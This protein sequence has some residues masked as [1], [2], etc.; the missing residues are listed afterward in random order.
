MDSFIRGL[1]HSPPEAGTQTAQNGCPAWN[2]S[3]LVHCINQSCRRYRIE[4]PIACPG[5]CT[6]LA[7]P[8]YGPIQEAKQK[9]SQ[10]GWCSR[11]NAVALYPPLMAADVNISLVEEGLPPGTG[12]TCLKMLQQISLCTKY[13][14]WILW[15]LYSIYQNDTVEKKGSNVGLTIVLSVLLLVLYMG[16]G[17]SQTGNLN[18]TTEQAAFPKRKK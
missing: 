2:S 11:C 10:R 16:T 15:F 8:G 18:W 4:K 9:E 7:A 3:L 6:L 13:H 5:G 1:H 12:V 14:Y 17:P